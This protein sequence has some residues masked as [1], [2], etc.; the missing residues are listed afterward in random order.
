MLPFSTFY[1]FTGFP[2]ISIGLALGSALG[3]Q[4]R[5]LA[6]GAQGDRCGVYHRARGPCTVRLDP[7]PSF[8]AAS[9]SVRKAFHSHTGRPCSVRG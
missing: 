7:Q 4:V 6:G 3:S 2:H 1:I 8:L 5:D 9:G